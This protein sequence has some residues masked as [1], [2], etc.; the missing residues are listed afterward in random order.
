ILGLLLALLYYRVAFKLA[1]DWI[2]ITDYS[3]GPL[4]PF[5]VFFLIWDK[6][7]VLRSTPRRPS[8]AGVSLV[9]L[10]LF[11]LLVGVFG[12]DLFLSRISFVILIAGLIWTLLGKPML[13]ESKCT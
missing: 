4:I 12:A 9:L 8:W 3:H 7:E 13:G 6:R 11:I 10:G 5:F 1:S 2:N